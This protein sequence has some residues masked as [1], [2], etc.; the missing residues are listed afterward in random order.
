MI[1]STSFRQ[2]VRVPHIIRVFLCAVLKILRA[3]ITPAYTCVGVVMAAAVR[4]CFPITHGV[5]RD[6][7][8]AVLVQMEEKDEL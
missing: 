4:G 6:T 5:A 1:T 2:R 8:V 7:A 3:S